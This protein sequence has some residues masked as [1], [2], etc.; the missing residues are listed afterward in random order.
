MR[1]LSSVRLRIILSR[2]ELSY[3]IYRAWISQQTALLKVAHKVF[4][5]GVGVT[6][7]S[8]VTQTITS[9]TLKLMP[10]DLVLIFKSLLILLFSIGDGRLSAIKILYSFI[11]CISYYLYYIYLLT[12]ASRS[13]VQLLQRGFLF[14]RAH[15][16]WGGCVSRGVVLRQSL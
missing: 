14:A 11:N 8:Q 5:M 16:A 10:I 1:I 6:K 9:G 2:V 4:K 15:R 12:T 13:I 7:V 3:T